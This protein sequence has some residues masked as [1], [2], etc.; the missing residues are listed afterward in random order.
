MQPKV[1]VA[2][3]GRK[4]D[5]VRL[6]QKKPQKVLNAF[7]SEMEPSLLGQ[8]LS[9]GLPFLE[10][11]AISCQQMHYFIRPIN[12]H[13]SLLP[14]LTSALQKLG[15]ASDKMQPWIITTPR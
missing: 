8:A 13:K 5:T 11:V 1:P 6:S 3:G 12:T 2:M 4:K 7:E 14:R 10:R 15:E 9:H